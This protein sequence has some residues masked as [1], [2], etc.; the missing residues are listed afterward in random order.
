MKQLSSL[1]LSLS[2]LIVLLLAGRA[3]YAQTGSGYDLSWN[4]VDSSSSPV[5][6]SGYMLT[7]LAG[8]PDAGMS[9]TGGGYTLAGGFWI[10][11]SANSRKSTVHLPIVLK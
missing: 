4:T 5:T 3:V 8:Q 6:G 11:G 1:A 10:E 9:L 7:G 2:I